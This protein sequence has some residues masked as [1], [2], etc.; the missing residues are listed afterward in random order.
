MSSD[1]SVP[2]VDL[3]LGASRVLS[4]WVTVVTLLASAAVFASGLP[5][6]LKCL[7]VTIIMAGTGRWLFAEGLRRVPH[8]VVRLVLMDEEECMVVER[9]G[10]Q[11]SVRV[12]HAAVITS[13]LVVVTLRSSGWRVRTLCVARDAVESNGFRRLRMRL[14]VAPP[15]RKQVGLRRSW[16]KPNSGIGRNTNV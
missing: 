13:S 12:V 9:A 6:W 3:T 1:R 8:S 11:R 14:S 10:I 2:V 15:A 16:L 5:V 7:I 4:L